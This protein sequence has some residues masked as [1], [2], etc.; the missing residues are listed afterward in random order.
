MTSFTS[1][2]HLHGDESK[3]PQHT[4]HTRLFQELGPAP[5]RVKSHGEA[6]TCHFI[7][8]NAQCSCISESK[9]VK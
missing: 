6:P 9:H 3:R 4:I 7:K 8:G 1:L 5:V 2:G